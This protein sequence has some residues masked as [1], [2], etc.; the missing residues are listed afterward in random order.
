MQVFVIRVTR[1]HLLFF[2]HSLKHQGQGRIRSAMWESLKSVDLFTQSTVNCV[3]IRL[4]TTAHSLSFLLSVGKLL[5][6]RPFQFMV[7]LLQLQLTGWLF[8]LPVN[9]RDSL[10]DFGYSCSLCFLL[11]INSDQKESVCRTVKLNWWVSVCP[12]VCAQ[13]TTINN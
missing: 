13:S 6:G 11:L 5:T 2:G 7:K 8:G 3:C 4:L 1:L 9:C 12:A 10:W